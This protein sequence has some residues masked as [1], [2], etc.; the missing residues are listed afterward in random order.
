MSGI[1]IYSNTTVG[2][3]ISTLVKTVTTIGSDLEGR[4]TSRPSST[5]LVP[6]SQPP[7]MRRAVSTPRGFHRR[8]QSLTVPSKNTAALEEDVALHTKK[9]TRLR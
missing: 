1:E 4:K 3:H 9:I 7:K 5:F 8:A 6:K 2:R